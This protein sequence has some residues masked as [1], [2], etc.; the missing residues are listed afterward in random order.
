MNYPATYVYTCTCTGYII[1]HSNKQNHT[2]KKHN[3]FVCTVQT[4]VIIQVHAV[5][6]TCTH[7]NLK[8]IW[9]TC[10]SKHVTDIFH[11]VWKTTCT[12]NC[13][14]TYYKKNY[15][16]VLFIASNKITNSALIV[17]M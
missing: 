2:R 1:I 16:Y 6:G 17:Y 13:N 5:T 9:I 11:F 14:L 10:N 7:I 4:Y 12:C 8:M 3:S 15:L